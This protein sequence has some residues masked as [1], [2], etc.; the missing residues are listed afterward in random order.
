[1]SQSTEQE[2]RLELLKLQA[3]NLRHVVKAQE[4][5]LAHLEDSITKG[6]SATVAAMAE[7]LK[8]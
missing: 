8:I 5:V 4:I 3:K 2:I 6:D 7:I 1:M